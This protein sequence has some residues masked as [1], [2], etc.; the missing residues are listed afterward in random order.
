MDCGRADQL[1][2]AFTDRGHRRMEA[3]FR[4][5]S[6]AQA[7]NYRAPATDQA[8][9]TVAQGEKALSWAPMN[10]ALEY[11]GT[12]GL[13]KAHSP[14]HQSITRVLRPGRISV[15][16]PPPSETPSNKPQAPEKFQISKHQTTKT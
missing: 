9:A 2:D 7:A 16:E 3:A 8:R 5:G 4:L 15:F 6:F 14:V 12:E 10:G 1:A 13:E 11:L